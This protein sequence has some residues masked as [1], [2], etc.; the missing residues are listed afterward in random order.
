MFKKIVNIR[1]TEGDGLGDNFELFPKIPHSHTA[2]GGVLA[3]RSG[4]GAWFVRAS[5]AAVERGSGLPAA[6]GRCSAACLVA[7]LG[8]QPGGARLVVDLG[9]RLVLALFGWGTGLLVERSMV[10]VA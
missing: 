1:P 10:W 4:G 3:A 5:G 7:K 6:S 9:G 8:G 2:A